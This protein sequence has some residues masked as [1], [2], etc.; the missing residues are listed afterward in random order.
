[1]GKIKTKKGFTLIEVLVSITIF[2]I[3]ITSVSSAYL[4]IAR[5]QRE[6]NSV[7]MI[8]SEMRYVFSL[9]GQEVKEKTIDYACT[10]GV[11]CSE[12]NGISKSKYLALVNNEGTKRTVFLVKDSLQDG[13]KKLY[14]YKE[15]KENG[16]K[17][18]NKAGGF[19][20]GYVEIELKN[21]ALDNFV[22]DISPLVDPFDSNNMGCGAIQFQPMVSIYATIHNV[23]HNIS[24]FK[25]DLQTAISS[26]VYDHKTAF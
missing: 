8:Y 11:S 12:L 10:N 6:A 7:R 17:V 13:V 1:M 16:D 19:E 22:F 21:I 25:L 26:R 4:N 24:N 5:K 3:F 18:W 20:N 2:M 15:T 23:N 14:F 9:I